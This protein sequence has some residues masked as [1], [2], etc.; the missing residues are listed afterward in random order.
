MARP[1]PSLILVAAV[2]M[3]VTATA[4]VSPEGRKRARSAIQARVVCG[5]PPNSVAPPPAALAAAWVA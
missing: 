4:R 2:L 1:R 5:R 3:G